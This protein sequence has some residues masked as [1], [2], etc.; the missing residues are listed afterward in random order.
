MEIRLET[1]TDYRN[2]EEVTREAFW[3]V[4]FPGCDEHLLIHNIRDSKDFIPALSFVAEQEGQIIGHIAYTKAIIIKEENMEQEIISF[5]PLS[6]LP[7]FQKQGIGKALIRH[8]LE[9]AKEMGYLA[10]CIYGDPRYYS[11]FGFR[12][13]ERYGIKNEDGVYAVPLMALELQEGALDRLSGCFAV[14]KDFIM[15]EAEIEAFDKSFPPKEK[16][17]TESQ[18]E[19]KVL[20]SLVY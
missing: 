9:A 6:V 19:Y 10:V 1:K 5:G 15:S 20:S 4:H 17:E 13:G 16:S 14:S 11:R 2:V 7:A 3:N 12:S 18:K 8:S